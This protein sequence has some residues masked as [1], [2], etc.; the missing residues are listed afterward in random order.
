M[1]GEHSNETRETQEELLV[2]VKELSGGQH[3]QPQ[4]HRLDENLLR[5]G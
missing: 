3:S 2:E 1:T 4:A 5:A